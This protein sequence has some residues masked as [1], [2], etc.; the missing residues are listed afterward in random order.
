MGWLEIFPRIILWV[1]VPLI[2]VLLLV[3]SAVLAKDIDNGKIRSSA[4]AGFWAG[5][6][7]ALMYIISQ[8][9][10]VIIPNFAIEFSIEVNIVA[11]VGGAISGFVLLAIVGLFS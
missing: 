4:V 3:Y 1:V 11:I 5:I 9:N 2:M 8:L 10:N 6:V 7:L